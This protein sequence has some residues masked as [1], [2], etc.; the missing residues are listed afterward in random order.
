M[1]YKSDFQLHLRSKSIFTKLCSC[2]LIGLIAGLISVLPVAASEGQVNTNTNNRIAQLPTTLSTDRSKLPMTLEWDVSKS[3]TKAAEFAW[4]SFLALNWP[5]DSNGQP[6]TNKIISRSPVSPRVWECFANPDDSTWQDKCG[7]APNLAAAPANPMR[8][9][10][11]RLSAKLAKSKLKARS[12]LNSIDS[13]ETID[14]VTT[15]QQPL[16]DQQQN[17][18]LYEIRVNK[19]EFTQ[20]KQP[21][22]GTQD[23]NFV[24]SAPDPTGKGGVSPIELKAAWRIFDD[25]N[26]DTEKSSYY[27]TK[28]N[29]C[30]RPE[31]NETKQEL[32]QNLELGLIGFHI[33]QK[34]EW[35]GA[36]GKSWIWSTF[37]HV[38]NVE[39]A[40][41]TQATPTLFNAACKD[42]AVDPPQD[43]PQWKV[44]PP[45]G[46]QYRP[47]QIKRVVPIQT[48]AIKSNQKWHQILKQDNPNSV[49]QN[50]QLIGNNFTPINDQ[51]IPSDPNSCFSA[52]KSTKLLDTSLE[53]YIPPRVF[54]NC[55]SC[56]INAG[57]NYRKTDFSFVV[58]LP[59]K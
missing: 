37:E 23:F 40:T 29:V 28:K 59:T 8:Q 20:L 48:D 27:I 10:R 35:Q 51:C 49:W 41:K 46:S 19:D 47:V 7:E 13:K 16:I 45:Y 55:A 26:S 6:L 14:L 38:N 43:K 11:K 17:F 58:N 24:A 52:T 32:C 21:K 39:I 42:C 31:D 9:D 44:K 3:G 50:Y 56:H 2:V 12:F 4:Q 53:P 5:A 15:T 30:I 36:T 54:P 57:Q 18:V 22:T 25:R 1:F 34:F 33:A